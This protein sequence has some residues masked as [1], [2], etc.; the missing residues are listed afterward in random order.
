MPHKQHALQKNRK[1]PNQLKL[2][3]AITSP[4]L[5]PSAKKKQ[6]TDSQMVAALKAVESGMK[7]NETTHDHGIPATTYS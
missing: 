3:L 2:L 4:V 5:H 6:W 7:I 1:M